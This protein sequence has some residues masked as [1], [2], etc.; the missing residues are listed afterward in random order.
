MSKLSFRPKSIVTFRGKPWR[1]IRATGPTEL[2]LEDVHTRTK[3]V[4]DVCNLEAPPQA[5]QLPARP[6]ESL[7]DDDLAEARR[8]LEIIKPLLECRQGRERLADKL[9]KQHRTSPRTLRRWVRSYEAR[10]LLSDLAPQRRGREMPRRLSKKVE[11]AIDTVIEEVFL[12]RQKVNARKAYEALKRRCAALK[13]SP[14]H[15][16]TFRRRL[17]EVS[18]KLKMERREGR[19]PAR[20]RFGEVKGAFPGADFPLA[21]VQ[22]DHTKLDI[23]LVDDETR[24]PIGRPWLTLAIDVYSRMVTGYYLSLD[25]PSAFSVGMCLAHSAGRK[26][27]DLERLA[28]KGDWPVW[29]IMHLIHADNGKE[30]RSKTIAKACEEYGIRIEWRPVWWKVRLLRDALCTCRTGGRRAFPSKRRGHYAR[31]TSETWLLV[32]GR[33]VVELAAVLHR[34]QSRALY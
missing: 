16:N 32:V 31:R 13:L 14:P 2:L 4:V 3:E 21:V 19:K 26:E 24:K 30:F 9:A 15:E 34:L 27:P 17:G 8:R 23:E 12:T 33:R 28:V 22:I 1:V 6:L 7:C 25:P 5:E 18:E 29:G 11:A 20:D 10:Q